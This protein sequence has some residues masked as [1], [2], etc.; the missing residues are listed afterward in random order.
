MSWTVGGGSHSL[1]LGDLGGTFLT[2]LHIS[3]LSCTNK[4]ADVGQLGGLDALCGEF[5]ANANA[6]SSF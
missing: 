4:H 6:S 5:Q 2:G 1:T 3:S